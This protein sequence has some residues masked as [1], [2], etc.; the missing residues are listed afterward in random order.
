M[1]KKRKCSQLKWKILASIYTLRICL[2]ICL[3]VSNKR[4]NGWKDWTQN[5]CGTWEGVRIIR[6]TNKFRKNLRIHEKNVN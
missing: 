5:L 4:Q 1:Y 6:I 3:F 2:G